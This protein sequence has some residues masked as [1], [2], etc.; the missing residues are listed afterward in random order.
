MLDELFAERDLD[1]WQELLTKQDGQWDTV[2]AAGQIQHDEQ[3]QANGYVQRVQHDGD[4]KV[5]LVSAP[6]QFDGEAPVLG[7]APT[8]G[9]DTDD[10][11]RAHGL[12]DHE[13]ADLRARG[14]IA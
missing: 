5:V 9:A 10:V 8:F 1:E 14:V 11:L 13:I 2:L 12:D 6:V 3:A 4:G 7:R